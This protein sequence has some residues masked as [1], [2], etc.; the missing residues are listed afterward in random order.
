LLLCSTAAAA[1]KRVALV[2]GNAA[3]GGVNELRN[4][5]NDA[6]AMVGALQALGFDVIEREN[7]GQREMN[8][9]I[10][11]FGE[12]LGED[13]VA[14]FYFSGHRMQVKGRNPSVAAVSQA[15]CDTRLQSFQ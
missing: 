3:Y 10:A 7:A 5:V 12:R 4:P 9:A 11:Q 14:L 13:V 15:G 1:E 8:R 6:R 2:I